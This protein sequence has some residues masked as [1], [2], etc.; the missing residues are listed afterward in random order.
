MWKKYLYFT[1]GNGQ[2]QHCA[3]CIGTVLFPI[4]KSQTVGRDLSAGM[5]RVWAE[6]WV[7]GRI[8]VYKV[9]R[10]SKLLILR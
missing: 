10:K 1:I 9:G 8:G 4:T 7:A 6:E 5:D 2:K 3:I